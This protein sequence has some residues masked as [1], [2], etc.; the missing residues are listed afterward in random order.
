MKVKIV[1]RFLIV[2]IVIILIL[3]FYSKLLSKKTSDV[4]EN[5]SEQETYSSNM[6]KNVK[7]LS[8]DAKGNK[9]IIVAK[10]GEIDL[11]DSSLI[12]LTEVNAVIDSK[13]SEK[14]TITSDYGKYNINNYDT[15]FSKNVL[16][17]YLEHKIKSE[18]A[19]FSFERNSM[20]VSKNVIYTNANKTLRSDVI[21]IDIKT[22][23]TKIFMHEKDAKVNITNRN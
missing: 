9:Y 10:Q 19:D 6:M 18:Y 4:K 5:I 14:I 17:I 8:E 23:D 13:E 12:Y 16:I 11:N 21:E 22:K 20:I 15:I 2:T 1:V 3:F 7:Y